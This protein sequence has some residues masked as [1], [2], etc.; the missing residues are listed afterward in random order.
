MKITLQQFKEACPTC[1]NPIDISTAINKFTDFP[2]EEL[3]MFIAQTSHESN[4]YNHL[5]ENLN[6][7]ADGLHSTWP[8]RF[9]DTATALPYARN[10]RKIANKVYADRMGNGNEESGDG[11]L[12]HGRG[13]IQLTGKNNYILLADFLNKSINELPEY[14][15]TSEGA[16]ASAVW[17][18]HENNISK[19]SSSVLLTTKAINGGTLGLA[20]RTDNFNRIKSI[21]GA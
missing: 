15:I 8:K 21:L 19:V 6:Y 5:E 3:A 12:Y 14:L 2:P 7:S 11:W 9:Q 17:F 4:Q 13:A 16:I 1:K 18:W 10:P 20:E